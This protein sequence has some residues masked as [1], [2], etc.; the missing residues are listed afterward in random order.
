LKKVL[1]TFFTLLAVGTILAVVSNI[2]PKSS[3]PT[4]PAEQARK[5]KETEDFSTK[6]IG[7]EQFDPSL[8]ILTQL[9]LE[10]PKG[11]YETDYM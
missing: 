4:S 8:R 11:K 5:A 2:E 7:E 10:N 1:K 6:A 9:Y 3:P